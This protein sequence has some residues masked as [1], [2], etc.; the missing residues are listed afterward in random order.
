MMMVLTPWVM[1]ASVLGVDPV[2]PASR[3]PGCTRIRAGH[4]GCHGFH[5]VAVALPAARPVLENG[6]HVQADGHG[7]RLGSRGRDPGPGWGAPQQRRD[8][9][10]AVHFGA[11]GRD[12]RVLVAAQAWGPRSPGARRLRHPAPPGPADQ[13][14]AG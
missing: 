7:G 9:C 13:P 8:R 12:P 2:V 6:T 5:H 10:A 14:G 3:W 1:T 4:G 11:H